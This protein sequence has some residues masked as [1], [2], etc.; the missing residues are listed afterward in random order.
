MND[1]KPK[2]PVDQL[3]ITFDSTESH[4][5]NTKENTATKPLLEDSEKLTKLKTNKDEQE[6]L[7]LHRA[8]QN[9]QNSY[10]NQ[11]LIFYFL[12][13]LAMTETIYFLVRW[14]M[15]LAYIDHGKECSTVLST[16]LDI[17]AASSLIIFSDL[18]GML[19]TILQSKWALLVYLLLNFSAIIYR[20]ATMLA[21]LNLNLV[22][23][24]YS[25]EF[26]DTHTTVLDVLVSVETVLS[27]GIL[28]LGWKLY[29]LA[30]LIT[31]KKNRL[32]LLKRNSETKHIHSVDYPSSRGQRQ[33]S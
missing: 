16:N 28:V 9:H 21:Y 8:L 10:K 14:S 17:I 26:W 13:C 29:S 25:I 31:S 7:Y 15:M 32:V 18:W 20:F 30:S 1:A 2:T 27:L 33:K 23:T 19:F 11:A 4:D 22:E 6:D 24:C 3:P 12:V 5:L